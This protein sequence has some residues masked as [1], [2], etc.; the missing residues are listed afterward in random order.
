MRWLPSLTT[1]A[2]HLLAR[3]Q[4][5]KGTYEQTFA[6]LSVISTLSWYLSW[7]IETVLAALILLEDT[8]DNMITRPGVW[9]VLFYLYKTLSLG[10][11]FILMPVAVGTAQMLRGRRAVIAGIGAAIIQCLILALFIR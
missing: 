7:L 2:A 8:V 11:Y 3:A 5:G 9:P 1:S 4:G 6:V 10:F